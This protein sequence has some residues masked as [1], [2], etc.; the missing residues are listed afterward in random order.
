MQDANKEDDVPPAKRLCTPSFDAL[1]DISSIDEL[2][3][4]SSI[5]NSLVSTEVFSSSSYL[6]GY[7]E[8]KNTYRIISLLLLQFK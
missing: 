1:E 7:I 4:Y 6:F 3:L 2:S 8:H 5:N